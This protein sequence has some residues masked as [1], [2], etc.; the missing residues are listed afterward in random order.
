MSMPDDILHHQHLLE[1]HRRSLAHYQVQLAQLGTGFAPP[2]VTHGIAEARAGIAKCKQV[3]RGLGVVV[4]DAPDDLEP[5]SSPFLRAVSSFIPVVREPAPDFV[6]REAEIAQVRRVYHRATIKGTVVAI[7]GVRGMGG[8]GKTELALAL[9]HSLADLFPD[10]QIFIELR[11]VSAP[12]S[13]SIALQSVLSQLGDTTPPTIDIDL[14]KQ[15]YRSRLHGQ[16]V[17]IIADDARDA[18]HV[19]P[20]L[21]PSGCGLLITS[22]QHFVVPGMLPEA[23]LNLRTLPES[24]AVNLL[25]S[26]CARIGDRAPEL[27]ML[28]GYLPLALRVSA[29]L[30]ATDESLGVDQY[31]KR[32]TNERTRLAQLHDPDS[33]EL[34]V[35]ASLRLSYDVLEK[36]AKAILCQLGT[37]PS[38]FDLEMALA[39]VSL[40]EDAEPFIRQLYRRSLLEWDEI[41]ERY[42]L[43]DL[44]R[45]LVVGELTHE[46]S[47]ELHQKYIFAIIHSYQS[48]FRRMNTEVNLVRID[49]IKTQIQTTADELWHLLESDLQKLARSQRNIAGILSVDIDQLA[50]TYFT[51]ILLELPK[52]RL[53]TY[54]N[55]QGYLIVVAKNRF[56]DEIRLDRNII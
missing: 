33:S 12:L 24:D 8:V 29:S 32:L 5:A 50:I 2:G 30:L 53:D 7:S 25:H 40:D 39:L 27:A 28:C 43:H 14:L 17:L 35:E 52:I 9:A 31:I 10:G 37:I 55:I 42:S 41:T 56:F 18:E 3:L 54:S 44:V 1:V 26:I 23:T 51:Y 38:S 49:Y 48:L 21:P 46:Q 4:G 45:A 47:L 19:R 36:T 13:P 22:R 34:D 16:R 20:L 6:G 11:G 15:R